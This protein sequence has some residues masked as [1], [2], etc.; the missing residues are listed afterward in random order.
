[1]RFDDSWAA[2]RRPDERIGPEK[3]VEA[4]VVPAGNLPAEIPLVVGDMAEAE[5]WER[6]PEVDA[7]SFVGDGQQHV[8]VA[9]LIERAVAGEVASSQ[10]MLH[11]ID[12]HLEPTGE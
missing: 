1:M 12:A 2:G 11:V 10:L 3:P 7:T 4:P 9:G 6:A 8:S 5:T